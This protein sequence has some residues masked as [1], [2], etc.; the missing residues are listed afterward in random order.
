MNFGLFDL[1]ARR[2]IMLT[3]ISTPPFVASQSPGHALHVPIALSGSED[4]L[5]SQPQP[6]SILYGVCVW[7]YVRAYQ[8]ARARLFM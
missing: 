3:F 4:V 7:R 5:D 1:S 2:L 8:Y 6:A